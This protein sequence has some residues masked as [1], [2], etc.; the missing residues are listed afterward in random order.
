MHHWIHN[1]P[2]VYLEFAYGSNEY[3]YLGSSW[4]CFFDLLL[5]L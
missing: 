3:T 1:K 2:V 4:K 5:K